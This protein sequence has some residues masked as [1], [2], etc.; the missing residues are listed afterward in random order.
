MTEVYGKAK[1][2]FW[3]IY[4]G[5]PLFSGFLSYNWLPQEYDERQHILIESHSVDCGMNGMNSCEVPDVWRDKD[6]GQVYNASQ[7]SEHRRY[8]SIRISI[9]SFLY[10]LIGCLFFAWDASR[11]KNM[12]FIG[13][14]K[15]ALFFDV[16]LSI[17][18]LIVL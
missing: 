7:F 8:E 4:I 15:N 13:A 14:F 5:L 17:V 12:T 6:S 2:L 3:L 18:I 10:G 1:S 16:A 9:L 11:S